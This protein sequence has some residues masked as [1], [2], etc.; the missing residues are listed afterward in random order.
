MHPEKLIEYELY[1][2]S[3]TK[4]DHVS[5]A[6]AKRQCETLTYAH[7][8]R[9]LKIYEANEITQKAA[10]E[11][12]IAFIVKGM[13]PLA[14]VEQTEFI[15]LIQGLCPKI[16][17]MSRRT[18]SRKIDETVKNCMESIK[19]KV[20]D[21]LHVCTTVDVWST[22]ARSFLGVTVHW[23]DKVMLSRESAALACRRFKGSH[24]YDRIAELLDEI[25]NDFGLT[26]D[27]IIATVSD[28]GSNFVKAFKEFGIDL[29]LSNEEGDEEESSDN[30]E[31]V[32][33]IS[34]DDDASVQPSVDSN[35]LIVLPNHIRCAAHTLN[36]V[37]TTDAKKALEK[38]PAF[39]RLN[40]LVMGKC[41]ALWNCG[42]RP[43]SA[44]I[45]EQICQRH[46]P[47]PCPTRWNSLFDCLTVLLDQREKLLQLMTSLNLPLFKDIEIEFLQEYCLTL[48]PIAMALDRLQGQKSSLY[49]ELLPTLFTTKAKLEA[50]EATKFNHCNPLLRAVIDGFDSRFSSFLHLKPEA[51]EAAIATMTHP[52]FKLRW[53]PDKFAGKRSR[54]QQLLITTTEQFSATQSPLI[55]FPSDTTIQEDDDDF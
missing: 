11:F 4:S 23:I 31:G 19:A 6:G 52:Y 53:L 24:T 38:S 37:A 17:V 18:L 28:N 49:G 14:T 48:R 35:K 41:S 47:Y 44:E 27:K 21:Q 12:I 1:K 25:H 30:F 7:P 43:K 29:S 33:F 26:H 2:K 32:T 16:S 34:I 15:N 50:L 40:H 45:I 55:P 9:Q 51:N 5:K 10:D 39:K 22:K 3:W 46:L 36:L 42:S 13:H 54:L 20:K 8:K